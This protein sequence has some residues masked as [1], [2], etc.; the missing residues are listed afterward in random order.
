MDNKIL[1]FKN[2]SFNFVEYDKN[3]KKINIFKKFQLT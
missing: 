3:S 2:Q 1:P